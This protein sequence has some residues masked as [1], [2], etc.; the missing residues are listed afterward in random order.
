MV[1][2]GTTLVECKLLN[3]NGIGVDINLE[4]TIVAWNRLDFTHAGTN[5]IQKLYQG[6]ARHLDLIVNDSV[7]LI[8]TH[9]P[10]ANIVPFSRQKKIEG[11]LS[12][13]TPSESLS[14][15]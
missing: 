7:D 10:Y 2:S 15:R 4:A 14:L 3:R 11:D 13:Y 8:A 12:H 6:D 5:T 9:P 1:G